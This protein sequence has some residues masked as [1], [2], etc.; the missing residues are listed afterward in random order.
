[1]PRNVAASCAALLMLAAGFSG[2]ACA[3]AQAKV[4]PE[5]PALD[6]P[7]PP[8]RIVEVSDPGVPP[9]LPL[10]GEPVRNVPPR[11]RS[12]PP[13]RTDAPKPQEPPK[14]D[15]P[16]TEVAKPAEEPPKPQQATTL[17]TT[18]AEREGEIDGRIRAALLQATADLNRINYQ[19]LNAD[20]RTQ[21]DTAKG[22]IRQAEDARRAKNLDF[23]RNLADKAA[24]LAAQ[25]AGR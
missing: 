10:P 20:A 18:P 6:M 3:R 13:A 8:P 1:M 9:P 15:Q 25:L 4:A 14:I 19:N 5:P 16:V 21:Y 17:Q 11:V 2:V 24:A 7:A 12:S 23:A 22:F